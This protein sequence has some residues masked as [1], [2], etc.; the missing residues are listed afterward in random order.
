MTVRHQWLSR[1]I[2]SAFCLGFA[3]MFNIKSSLSKYGFAANE[4]TDVICTHLH[5]VDL[6]LQHEMGAEIV[7]K[8][9][10]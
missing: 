2:N 6:M 1:D 3:S 9:H 5:F 10:F 8:P 4:I 7:L